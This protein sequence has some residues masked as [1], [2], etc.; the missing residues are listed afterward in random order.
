M[1]F[2]KN[3]TLV[4]VSDLTGSS[5]GNTLFYTT[6]ISVLLDDGRVRPKTCRRSVVFFKNIVV[7]L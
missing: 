6:T 3:T 2:L 4:C 1:I 5:T 7:N